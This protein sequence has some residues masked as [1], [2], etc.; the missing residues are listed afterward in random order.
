MNQNLDNA[1]AIFYELI[2]VYREA[3]EDTSHVTRMTAKEIDESVNGYIE[4]WEHEK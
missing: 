2:A 3:L 1:N 4:K